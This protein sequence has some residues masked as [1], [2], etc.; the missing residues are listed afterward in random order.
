L[1]FVSGEDILKATGSVTGSNPGDNFGW[2]ATGVG[3]VNGDGFDDILVGAPKTDI[4]PKIWWDENWAY[5]MKLMFDN[6]G[7]MQTLVNFPVLVTLDSSHFNYLNAKPDGSDLRFIEDGKELRYHIETWNPSGESHIWVNVNS[8]GG[9]SSSDFMWMY[10][11][12]SGASNS[13]DISGTYDANFMGVWHLDE[14]SGI[15][16]DSTSYDNDGIPQGGVTQSATGKIDG[17]DDFDG[18]MDYIDV[19]TSSSLNITS[20]ITIEAWV[21]PDDV[22][23]TDADPSV[24]SKFDDSERAYQLGF[25]DDAGDSD[26][27]DFRLSSDGTS[28]GGQIHVSNAVSNNQWQYITGTWDGTDMRLYKN[29][30]EIGTSASFAGPIYSSAADVWIGDGTYYGSMDGW[31]DE[32]RI[33]NKARSADWIAA[34][35]LSMNK[36]FITYVP[37]EINTWWNSEWQYRKSLIFENSGQMDTLEN[38]PVLVTLDS[39]NFNY[40]KAKPDG[41]DLRFID[42]TKELKYHIEKWNALG[43]SYVWVNVSFISAGSSSDFILMYYGNPSAPNNQDITGTY[44]AN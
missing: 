41:S 14:T 40:S 37:E 33:S 44:D 7:Q 15:H 8:I 23:H 11:G 20:G 12:N 35:Y 1:G 39:S 38:F 28:S 17:A 36:N 10:Y 42:G 24:V 22:D 6:S 3:D 18:D 5:R 2:N 29:G 13:Q 25:N 16:Y 43:K 9:G 30:V 21:R 27:W 31:I 26:D 32:V 4:I 19:G 34:Q